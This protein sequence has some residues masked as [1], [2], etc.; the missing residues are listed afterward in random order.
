MRGLDG[1]DQGWGLSE[2]G[3]QRPRGYDGAGR[4]DQDVVERGGEQVCQSAGGDPVVALQ[5][6]SSKGG[7]TIAAGEPEGFSLPAGDNLHFVT[8]S[9]ACDTP[10]TR[11]GG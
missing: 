6:G 8:L 5:Q 11:K 9:P 2:G 10:G 3:G 7:Q 1:G 4:L